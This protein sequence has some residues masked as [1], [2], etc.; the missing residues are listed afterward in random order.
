MVQQGA[1]GRCVR[2]CL[3]LSLSVPVLVSVSV[4]VFDSLVAGRSDKTMFG[5]CSAQCAS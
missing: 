2:V 4:C 1:E 3:S 5:S